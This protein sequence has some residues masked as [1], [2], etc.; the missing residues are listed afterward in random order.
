VLSSE[1]ESVKATYEPIYIY[2][3]LYISV[4]KYWKQCKYKG[5]KMSEE[6]LCWYALNPQKY[7]KA[8][9]Q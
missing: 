1:K 2:I 3:K 5:C 4:N 7:D 9:I 8:P 6:I